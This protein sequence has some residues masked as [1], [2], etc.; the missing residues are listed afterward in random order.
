MTQSIQS[1]SKGQGG[2]QGGTLVTGAM[3]NDHPLRVLAESG[4]KVDDKRSPILWNTPHQRMNYQS[5][6]GP[7][8]SYKAQWESLRE[9]PA[10]MRK[11][12]L[13]RY[14]EMRDDEG[15]RSLLDSTLLRI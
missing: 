4:Y 5:R 8:A 6:F 2:N 11:Q 1:K 3:S 13:V 10:E 14:Q 12:L 15:C 7:L 9:M